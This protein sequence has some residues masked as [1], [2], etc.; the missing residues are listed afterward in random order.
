[1]SQVDLVVKSCEIESPPSPNSIWAKVQLAQKLTP[2][3]KAVQS[4]QYHAK[5]QVGSVVR[6]YQISLTNW[7]CASVD[8]VNNN[9][10]LKSHRHLFHCI[11][12]RY[13]FD[14]LRCGRSVKDCI[15]HTTQLIVWPRSWL[16]MSRL[17]YSSGR[18]AFACLIQL[19][20]QKILPICVYCQ[21]DNITIMYCWGADSQPCSKC[22]NP[23]ECSSIRTHCQDRVIFSEVLRATSPLIEGTEINFIRGLNKKEYRFGQRRRRSKIC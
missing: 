23:F 17:R 16:S 2:V 7:T 22:R 14:I 19:A 12:C 8:E 11:I 4:W 15:M 5:L 6:V 13:R 3:R 1:M 20:W 9:F 18:G 10:L 21:R